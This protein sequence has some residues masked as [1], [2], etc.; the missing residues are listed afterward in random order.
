ME[1]ARLIIAIALSL[2]VFI[3]WNFFFADKKENL[4][5]KLAQE[6]EEK[7]EKKPENLKKEQIIVE[8]PLLSP[9]TPDL[10]AKPSRTLTVKTPLYVVKISEKGAVFKSYI[11]K[12]YR[13][14]TSVDS[15][16]L[17]MIPPDISDGTIRL[18]VAG[19]SL[20]G[21]DDAVFSG[22]VDGDSV[23]I[24]NKPK[25]ISFVWTSS[26]GVAVEKKFSFSPDTYMIDLSVTLKNFSG[27]PLRDSLFFP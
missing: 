2:L 8:K 23:D 25:E 7:I 16:L 24:T 3:L 27:A 12:N 26:Q 19:N 6:Q 20:G 10:P 5:A 13:E 9:K 22:D 11:L 21:L 17:E 18:G 1:Q 4:P 15:P 14:T